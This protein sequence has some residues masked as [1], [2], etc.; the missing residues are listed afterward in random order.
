MGTQDVT[1]ILPALRSPPGPS[2]TGFQSTPIY[3]TIP[4]HLVKHATSKTSVPGHYADTDAQIQRLA[5]EA[6]A[7]PYVS[8]F[9]HFGNLDY[10]GHKYG[11]TSKEYAASALDIDNYMGQILRAVDQRS[12][13]EN[14]DWLV[15][16]VSDHGHTPALSQAIFGEWLD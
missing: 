5:L 16:V 11:S 6:V 9:V 8:T 2:S 15:A 13:Y 4:Y 10:E 1:T 14:E 7:G 3:H 12:A